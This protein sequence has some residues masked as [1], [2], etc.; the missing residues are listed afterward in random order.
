MG[1]LS[2]SFDVRYVWR[3]AALIALVAAPALHAQPPPPAPALRCDPLEPQLH[4][5]AQQTD[6][7]RRGT[8]AAAEA[9]VDNDW[10]AA[11]Q[12]GCAVRLGDLYADVG[13]YRAEAPMMSAP[14]SLRPMR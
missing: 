14:A 4:R 10:P 12:A 2:A 1:D 11:I 5:A 3:L 9:A 13:D 6:R 7:E 8:L